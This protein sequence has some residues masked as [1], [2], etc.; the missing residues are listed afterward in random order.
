V[1]YD[2]PVRSRGLASTV[3][4]VSLAVLIA[5]ASI[6]AG[7]AIWERASERQQADD[8]RASLS[9]GEALA[10]SVGRSLA[11]MRASSGLVEPDGSVDTGT[12]Y[13]FARGITVVGSANAVVLA[14]AVPAA[15]RTRFEA[16]E[17]RP[18]I[19]V[20]R[21]GVY[22]RAPARARY[23]PVVAVWPDTTVNQPLLGLDLLRDAARRRAADE[24]ARRRDT[25]LTS[26]VPLAVNRQGFLAF[27]PLYAPGRARGRPVAYVTASFATDLIG[28]ELAR[29]ASEFRIRVT[30][31]DATVYVTPEPPGGGDQR[32]VMLAGS[33]WVVRAEGRPASRLE[34][35]VVAGT[36]IALAVLLALFA[37]TR[38]SSERRLLRANVA[39][40][41]ALDR[42]EALARDAELLATV[43]EALEQSTTAEGRARR[44]V[45]A[46]VAGGIRFAGVHLGD[47]ET[48]ALED[49][50]VAGA[51]PPELADDAVW[52]AHVRR[53]VAA[54]GVLPVRARGGAE[55]PE[56]VVL[57]LRARGRALG[58]LTL[59]AP[60]GGDLRAVST[61]LAR[62]VAGVAAL[63]LDNARLYERE[64]GVSHA[65]QLGLLGKAPSFANV[66]ISAAYRPGAAALEIGG[67]WYDA[68]ELVDG[69]VALVVGDVV[70]HG[71]AAAVAMGQLRGAVRALSRAG[72][73]PAR[74]LQQLDMF[75]ES[76]PDAAGATLAYAELDPE[77][78]R[79]VYACAG[80]PPP[81]VVPPD[82]DARYLWDGRSAPLGS[83]LGTERTEA[84]AQLAEGDTIVLYTDGLIERR[85][86]S[87]DD[88]LHRLAAEAV[89]RAPEGDPLADDLADALLEGEEQA[90]DVCVLTARRFPVASMFSHAF[91]ARPSELAPL[92][93]RL[94]AWLDAQNVDPEAQRGVVLAVSE[95]A[96]NAVEHGHGSD[97][98]GVVS[99]MARMD[100]GR[101]A[102]SVRDRGGWREPGDPGERG[103][104]LPI[105]EAIV[106]EV[107][108]EQTEGGTVVRM[109]SRTGAV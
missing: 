32:T 28:R 8:E 18:I 68:F 20:V 36:G 101:V 3:V 60:G 97:G 78:G 34:P 72:G 11:I 29:L 44:L 70:G 80:H 86:E 56:L 105:I 13:G 4:G 84:V 21:P 1:W 96:A 90:D 93:Q 2:R 47:E 39:A 95:A 57:P 27:Q 64:R 19:Q 77:A 10:T 25:V 100:D 83:I 6:V 85:G 108:I 63:A 38:A 89:L 30:S 7:W 42:S 107:S 87:L 91:R 98:L 75:V 104:G 62:E 73:G 48:G 106:D 16:A 50:A 12:F 74:V 49:I 61:G 55:E 69:S 99:V 76:V 109:Q 103:R 52:L 17:R 35:F 66:S 82:G 71:L 15:G 43:G 40:E 31:G 65:L 26:L 88:G 92:R 81:L 14:R 94:G 23:L 45:E 58:T 51:R 22:E 24:A 5:L 46:L 67:D 59:D 102:L 41:R 9:V 37:F 54:M 79:L 33:P 53:A